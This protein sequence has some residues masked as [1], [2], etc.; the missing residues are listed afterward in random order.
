MAIFNIPNLYGSFYIAM[1]SLAICLFLYSSSWYFSTTTEI[2]EEIIDSHINVEK[3][4]IDI[5]E[6]LDKKN[7]FFE[8]NNTASKQVTKVLKCVNDYEFVKNV[9]EKCENIYGLNFEKTLEE[10]KN[11]S[12]FLKNDITKKQKELYDVLAALLKLK[13]KERSFSRYKYAY[14]IIAPINIALIFLFAYL[15]YV[16]LQRPTDAKLLEN[17]I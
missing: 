15:W 11:Q 17:N 13:E 5:K 3:K 12:L 10:I 2:R 16:R 8:K 7:E 9:F 14:Y 4:L 1:F 6:I